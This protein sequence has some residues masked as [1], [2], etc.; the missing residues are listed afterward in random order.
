MG[1]IHPLGRRC[2]G[3]GNSTAL[4]SHKDPRKDLLPLP[5][6]PPRTAWARTPSPLAPWE[7]ARQGA[8]PLPLGHT[9]PGPA[10]PR[11]GSPTGLVP[12]AHL[13]R[14]P[15]HLCMGPSATTLQ[16]EPPRRW[17]RWRR[18]FLAP[19]TLG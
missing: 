2:F 5:R 18:G 14:R 8:G 19:G 10:S 1:T 13:G 9:S 17:A 7:S 3:S 15:G 4:D 12:P 11:P 6:A 16:E